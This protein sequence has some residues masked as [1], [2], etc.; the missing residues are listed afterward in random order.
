VRKNGMSEDGKDETMRGS[1][2]KDGQEETVVVER[3]CDLI[4]SEWKLSNSPP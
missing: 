2:L 4:G 1:S 3:C